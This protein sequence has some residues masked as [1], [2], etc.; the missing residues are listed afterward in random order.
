MQIIRNVDLGINVY[1]TSTTRR[2]S[3]S[4]IWL[5]PGSLKN[6]FLT[7]GFL[8]YQEGSVPTVNQ[9]STRCHRRLDHISTIL[10]RH[11]D[12]LCQP[13]TDRHTRVKKNITYS[14]SVW[15]YNEEQL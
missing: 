6:V 10:Q 3:D 12:V 5:K 8:F 9:M 14:P 1:I 15:V 2:I 4:Q 7:S 13:G 11:I